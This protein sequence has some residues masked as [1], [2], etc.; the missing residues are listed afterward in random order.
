MN[1]S[2]ANDTNTILRY[3][4]NQARWPVGVPTDAEAQAAAERLADRAHKPL[5]AGL[6]AQDVTEA[7]PN[8][9]GGDT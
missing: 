3:L 1:I 8:R 4:L 6:R 5:S 9:R 2:E 7:W